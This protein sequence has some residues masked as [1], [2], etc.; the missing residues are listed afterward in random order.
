[1]DYIDLRSD[2]VTMPTHAMRE[3][4]SRAQVGDDV[5]GEDPTVNRLQVMSAEVMGKEAGLFVA[6]G[7]MGNLVAI[8]AFCNRGDEVIVGNK[9]HTF[10]YEAGGVSALGG[11]HSCQIINQSDGSLKIDD[12]QGAF[13]PDDA[14]EPITRLV[15]LENSH[16]RCGGTV[17]TR[18]YTYRVC[19]ITH[20]QGINVHMDGARVFNAAAALG[21]TVAELVAPVD[22]IT[23]CL[24]KGLCAPVGSVLCGSSDFIT[25]ASRIRKML[26]GG[27]RQ[28][29]IL[30]AAGMVAL[31]SMVLRIGEDHVRA[32]KL[33][34][35]IEETQGLSLDFGKPI[36]NMVFFSMN[37]DIPAN[38]QRISD[39][40]K[41]RGILFGVNGH[42][43]FRLVTNYWVDDSGVERTIQNLREVLQAL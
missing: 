40:M 37:S 24:S 39:E 25:K 12:I 4:M 26:G 5:Y 33:A 9:S 3:A 43:G 11:V 34:E 29:G 31:E 13:R 16:N 15:C 18:E 30:A 10:L 38:A 32:K 14:H 2:T 1:M 8:L 19:D 35:G 21:I 41:K 22:S 20:E 28:A 7:T 36:T 6:S 27:M 42:R 17:Q 23:F